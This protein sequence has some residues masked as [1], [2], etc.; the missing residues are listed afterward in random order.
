MIL[1]LGQAEEQP[2]D[3]KAVDVPIIRFLLARLVEV[4]MEILVPAA[5]HNYFEVISFDM[6]VKIKFLLTF[7][8]PIPDHISPLV[9]YYHCF[10]FLYLH[11]L[12]LEEEITFV[13][14][15][16]HLHLGIVNVL[17]ELEPEVPQNEEKYF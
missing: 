1:L 13:Q 8:L 5:I 2:L 17:Y 12:F 14:S 11:Q 10:I 16:Y 9:Y 4:Q 15:S 7:N 6:A 3:G